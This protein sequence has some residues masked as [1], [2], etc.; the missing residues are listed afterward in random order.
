MLLPPSQTGG[1]LSRPHNKL[2]KLVFR[3]PEF[4]PSHPKSG[5]MMRFGGPEPDSE[6]E[7]RL[8]NA[9]VVGNAAI[10]AITV[11]VVNVA[12]YVLEQFGFDVVK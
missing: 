6:E 4:F 8:S 5:K 11:F 7:R 10:F 1:N 2:D 12:P 9:A 3:P